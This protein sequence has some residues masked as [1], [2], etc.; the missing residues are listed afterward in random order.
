MSALVADAF[1]VTMWLVCGVGTGTSYSLQSDR[2]AG[3]R[4]IIAGVLVFA[5]PIGLLFCLPTAL[6]DFARKMDERRRAERDS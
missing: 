2:S 5:G 6:A 4:A 3:D 1:L